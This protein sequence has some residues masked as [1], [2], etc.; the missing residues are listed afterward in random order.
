MAYKFQKGLARLDGTIAL[1]AAT[2]KFQLSGS[3]EL[4]DN[5]LAVNELD[6]NGGAALAATPADGD[7]I[8]IAD[9]DDS[10]TVKKIA[11][12]QL[13]TYLSGSD[14]TYLQVAQAL[15]G[16]TG[17][18][19][20]SAQLNVTGA[21]SAS[22][23][24]IIGDADLNEADLEQIDGITAGTVAAS[25]AVVVDSNKDADGFRNISGS[26][27]FEATT[28]QVGDAATAQFQVAADG[29]VVAKGLQVDNGGTI[30]TDS[31]ADML[32]LTNASDVTLA[33]D[34]ELRFA[35]SGERIRRSADGYLDIDVGTA[36]NLSGAVR[37]TDDVTVAG[38]ISGSG[39]LAGFNMVIQA[40]Q[41]IGVN[42]DTDLMKL[43]SGKV[44]INGDL[45]I[46][47]IINKITTRETEL[48]IEDIR[49]IIGSG[50]AA[51]SELNG[52]GI[53]FGSGSAGV[54]VAK[55]QFNDAA[56]DEIE[57]LFSGSSAMK[58]DAGGDLT[59]EGAISGA[60]GTFDALAG[61]SL[62]LQSGGIT[63]AGSIAGATTISGSGKLEALELEI[64]NA[65]N[66]FNV[67]ADGQLTANA[68]ASLDGGINVDDVF[69]V[70]A[71]GAVLA[72]SLDNSNG[73]ITNAG[74]IAGVT[75]LDASGLAS[76]DGGINVNDAFTVD[77]AGSVL[78]V[79]ATISN[80]FSAGSL[81]T[82]GS[83]QLFYSASMAAM[84]G[85][86][87]VA[88]VNHVGGGVQNA[89]SL[90]TG[91]VAAAGY[92]SFLA[93][94]PTGSE[95]VK[96]FLPAN[97]LGI[98]DSGKVLTIKLDSLADGFLV[99]TGSG[100]SNALFDG[101]AA[102]TMSSPQGAIN[103]L[104]TGNSYSLF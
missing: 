18:Y 82:T 42:G 12:S 100:A 64:G 103:L 53:I 56:Q 32:T 4:Q 63:A 69:T 70:S 5:S 46:S 66:L 96:M 34:I 93:V 1:D 79:D 50:S 77:N 21:V 90:V 14:P 9:V 87:A 8:M 25:K 92:P 101:E 68:L 67:A 76:L 89:T 10:N 47:G 26:G 73:G 91:S 88:D 57:F 29:G 3:V 20:L 35:D 41:N 44:T 11:M 19:E 13:A 43:E 16:V 102:L 15:Q 36:L 39:G 78:G 104:W 60:A 94:Q 51:A 24:F 75:T 72:A 27:L 62:A 99:L 2:D 38:D 81:K 59:A 74:A 33:S 65:D 23:S 80:A 37:T 31:D 58:I 55:I 30:G 98:D 86:A 7:L 54:D 49:I 71:A 48:A 83:L 6:V 52:G 97:A 22:T 28:L 61:T 84:G 85:L 40:G 45:D 17:S 95:D